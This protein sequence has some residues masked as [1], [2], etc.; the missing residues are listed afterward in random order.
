MDNKNI[1]IDH[2]DHIDHIVHVGRA[3]KVDNFKVQLPKYRYLLLDNS[4]LFLGAA[5][6]VIFCSCG[7][8]IDV[9]YSGCRYVYTS[10]FGLTSR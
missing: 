9:V 7:Y 4:F 6:A 1:N 5:A 10:F 2:I 8:V 3:D